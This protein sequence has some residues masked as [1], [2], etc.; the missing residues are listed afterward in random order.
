M[1]RYK[2]D[3]VS[4]ILNDYLREYQNKL[5][6]HREQLNRTT[7]SESVPDRDKRK[8]QKELDLTIKII[9]DLEDYEKNI[10]YP[11]ATEKI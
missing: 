2:P 11:L 10:L 7:I 4:V 9:K 5:N 6:S 8:A 1:H 3:T